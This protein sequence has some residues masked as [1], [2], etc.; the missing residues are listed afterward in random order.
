VRVDTGEILG[1][2][3]T[4]QHIGHAPKISGDIGR[5]RS[6]RFR[7]EDASHRVRRPTAR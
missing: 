3:I 2:D 4:D 1:G 5:V 6:V 7:V